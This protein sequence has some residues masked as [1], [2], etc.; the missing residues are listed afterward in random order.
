MPTFY[1]EYLGNSVELPLGETLVGR[2]VGCALRFNDAAVSRKHLRLIR[3][4]DEVFIED[5]SSRN[6]TLVNGR[7][8]VTA[9]RLEDGDTISV[10]SRQLVVRVL[11]GSEE[12]QATLVL[13]DLSQAEVK[14]ARRQTTMQMA[15]TVPPPKGHQRCPTCGAG[16]TIT[17]DSCSNCGYEWGSFRPATP[18]REATNP[19]SRRRHERQSIELRLIYSSAELEVEAATRDLSV[20]GVFVCSSVLDTVGTRCELSIL[21][22]GG[23][24]L[25]VHGIVRRVVEKADAEPVGLGIEFVELGTAE[26]DWINSIAAHEPEE[27]ADVTGPI[28]SG[29]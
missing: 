5:L 3:R 27:R 10:G 28:R 19:L 11:D 1:L 16:V 29:N 8:M 24:P 9:I 15:V 2:D 14:S 13:K 21:I 17:D 25:H 23:P 26:R 4:L 6:G 7:V 18:T 12:E 20:S 22:D